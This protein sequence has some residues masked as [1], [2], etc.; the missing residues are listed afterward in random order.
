M[1]WNLKY[2]PR[3]GRSMGVKWDEDPESDD[4]KEGM[5]EKIV[6]Q[7]QPPSEKPM[8]SKEE[9]AWSAS[10]RS[11]GRSIPRVEQ[12]PA[13]MKPVEKENKKLLYHGKFI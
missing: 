1:K 8:P 3:F 11:E 9:R 13:V 12:P 7:Y 5:D 6:C 2:G 10:K 4:E